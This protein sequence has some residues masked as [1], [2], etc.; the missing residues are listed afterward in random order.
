M[1]LEV[2]K[3]LESDNLQG[4]AFADAFANALSLADVCKIP[5]TNEPLRREAT[6]K[7]KKIIDQMLDKL[8]AP[9]AGRNYTY[10]ILPDGLYGP[11]YGNEN[12]WRDTT[13]KA[14][15]QKDSREK[16]LIDDTG[17][18]IYKVFI[19]KSAVEKLV[20]EKGMSCKEAEESIA[21]SPLMT[22]NKALWRPTGEEA[23]KIGEK[24]KN[25]EA[26][27]EFVRIES[28]YVHLAGVRS[29]PKQAMFTALVDMWEVYS[30]R[31]AEGE[32]S[33]LDNVAIESA[34]EKTFEKSGI[35]I[36]VDEYIE[37]IDDSYE[38]G[39]EKKPALDC[40]KAFFTKLATIKKYP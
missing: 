32:M 21:A 16:P 2:G 38:K 8:G 1:I 35:D 22:S 31:Y 40:I 25:E 3:I 27:D 19:R 13:G 28:A 36:Q 11:N 39:G 12:S 14:V 34:L 37:L 4:A 6:E 23:K 24:L 29:S 10:Y 20:S 17:N 30:K 15:I 18:L 7:L 9:K 33:W 5:V 26:L